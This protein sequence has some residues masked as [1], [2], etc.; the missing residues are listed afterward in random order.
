[1][2][3]GFGHRHSDE[4][5]FVFHGLGRWWILETGKYGYDKGAIREHVQSAQAHNGIT[6]NHEG[7]RPLDMKDPTKTVAFE[8]TLISAPALAR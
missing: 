7:M 2:H 1:M 3:R 4:M 5:S 8:P 6:F